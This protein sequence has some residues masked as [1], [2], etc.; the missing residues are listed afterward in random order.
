MVG[1]ASVLRHPPLLL[2]ERKGLQLLRLSFYRRI[3]IPDLNRRNL[4]GEL[5]DAPDLDPKLH[6]LALRGLKRINQVT[7]S[8][9]S[10]WQAIQRRIHQ[11][12]CTDPLT[13]LD[14]GCGSADS[15]IQFGR[16]AR[17]S[18][19]ELQL[20][21]IDIGATTI[22][23]ARS[24]AAE[25]DVEIELTQQDALSDDPFPKH[26]IVFCSLFLHH[27]SRDQA[28]TLLQKMKQSARRMV[29]VS[30]LLR[31]TWGYFLSVAGTRLLSRSSIVHID[32]PRSV[33]AAFTMEEMRLLGEESGMPEATI[34]KFWPERFL[35]Q[36]TVSS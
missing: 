23:M 18:N 25:A 24:L 1:H 10:A 16:Y 26:D 3:F 11:T 13:I 9:K 34:K 14:V 31:S 2:D 20:S 8:S 4:R 36:W 29:L 27:L 22:Q 35:F 6:R 19:I 32:G 5:M 21:G 7:K 30:D 33:E 17:Q 12:P 15:L 28:T